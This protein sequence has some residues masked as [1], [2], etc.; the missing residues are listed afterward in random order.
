MGHAGLSTDDQ[1]VDDQLR[2]FRAAGERQVF[3]E[4]S[5]GS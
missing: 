1:R 4:T 5:S 2:R 3:R